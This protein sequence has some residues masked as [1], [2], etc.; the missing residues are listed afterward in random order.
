MCSR[1]KAGQETYDFLL[2]TT[3]V[4]VLGLC[5]R[6]TIIVLLVHWLVFFLEVPWHAVAM[7]TACVVYVDAWMMRSHAMDSTCGCM[8]ACALAMLTQPLKQRC[9]ES[10]ST[11]LWLED[12][13]WSFVSTLEVVGSVSGMCVPLPFVLKIV[14]GG[15]LA[16]LHVLGSCAAIGALEMV[17]R[18]VMFYVMCAVC[19]LCLKFTNVREAERKNY[20]SMIPHASM[21]VLYVHLYAA[22]AGF[23]LVLGAHVRLVFEHRRKA[24]GADV[25]QQ[26]PGLRRTERAAEK[27]PPGGREAAAPRDERA[28]G[29]YLELV[30]SLQAAKTAG[31]QQ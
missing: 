26:G 13:A 9:L 19:V 23:L 1:E 20:T 31:G 28:H 3:Y 2:V 18:A 7:V 22:L 5:A 25:E 27:K 15:A 16:V 24:P 10:T 21:H 17:L 30:R 8:C 12:F 11:L 29:E 4:P 14:L 6:S